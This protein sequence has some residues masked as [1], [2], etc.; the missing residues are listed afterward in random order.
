MYPAVIRVKQ[1][2]LIP[3]MKRLV[4]ATTTR[5]LRGAFG[6]VSDVVLLRRHSEGILEHQ[7]KFNLNK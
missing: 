5:G 2:D 6:L 4:S 7:E 3:A 1:A